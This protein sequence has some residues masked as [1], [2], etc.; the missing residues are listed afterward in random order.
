[1]AKAL[2]TLMNFSGFPEPF[3]KARAAAYRRWARTYHRQ[4]VRSDIRDAFAVR[5]IDTMELLYTLLPSRVGSTLSLAK[6]TDPLKT[7]HKTISSWISVF[8]Q[9]YLVFR[10][11]PYS[12]RIRRSILK[13]PKLYFY[14][15]CRVKDDGK[16]FENL[17][18]LELKR[19]VSNWTDYGLGEF[20]L[21]FLRTKEHEE[22]D[23]LV[24]EGERPLFMVEVKS[25]ALSP[26]PTLKKFQSILR[27]PA[28]QLVRRKGTNRVFK[29]GEDR[30]LVVNAAGWLSRL[31]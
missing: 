24:T 4:I 31:G 6:L 19:A 26:S 29:N 15:Y 25:G 18:A 13:E 10:V 1:M 16:R 5:D 21:F 23:F 28:V 30:I 9:L 17:V 22:V 8:E 7:S 11:R 27:V 12:R 3:L 2:K 20:S 14:D